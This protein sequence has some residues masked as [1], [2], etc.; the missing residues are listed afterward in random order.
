MKSRTV[1]ML[2]WASFFALGVL[3]GGCTAESFS[4]TAIAENLQTFFIDLGRQILTAWL[5]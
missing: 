4:A 1:I 3:L 5:L 2:L